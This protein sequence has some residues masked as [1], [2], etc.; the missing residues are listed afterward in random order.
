MQT[1]K[2]GAIV[3]LLATILFSAYTSLTAPPGDLPDELAAALEFDTETGELNIDT[4]LP[5]SLA[6]MNFADPSENQI[7]SAEPSG[8]EQPEIAYDEP[9]GSFGLPAPGNADADPA[10]QTA[11]ATGPGL[12]GDGFNVDRQPE[13]RV[14]TSGVNLDLSDNRASL[15]PI[16]PV[17]GDVYPKTSTQFAMPDPTTA[18]SPFARTDPKTA[19]V[20][21]PGVVKTVSASTPSRGMTSAEPTDSKDPRSDAEARRLANDLRNALNQADQ[22]FAQ[23]SL[24]E[25]LATLSLFYGTPDLSGEQRAELLSRLDYLAAQVIY[26][27]SHLL[28]VPYRV[29]ADET[30]MDIA[31]KFDVQWQLLANINEIRD[32]TAILPGTELK[33][34]RGPFRAEVRLNAQELTLFLG[35]LYAGRFPLGVGSQPT[36]TPGHYTV[37]DKQPGRTFYDR[38]GSAIAVGAPGNPYGDVWIDL[39]AQVCLHGSPD[40]TRPTESGCLSVPGDYAKDVFGILSVGSSVDI[41][42]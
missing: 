28:E 31:K 16:N 19:T 14:A 23:G 1:L 36:P 40:L 30:L 41:E 32:P 37:Q 29:N 20:D 4:G 15:P 11:E 13:D 33:V 35:D 17:T 27:K 24:K 18:E 9:A 26:S 39:G 21:T 8:N 25:A 6:E 10:S 5:P 12:P 2:T 42:P 22:L 7:A 34:M 3:V 38:S